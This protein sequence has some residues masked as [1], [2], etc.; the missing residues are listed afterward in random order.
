MNRRFCDGPFLSHQQERPL[1][2]GVRSL[3][4]RPAGFG[5]IG[6]VGV[7]CSNDTS[8]QF[9]Q[10]SLFVNRLLCTWLRWFHSFQKKSY[11]VTLQIESKIEPNETNSFQQAEKA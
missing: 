9:E 3:R 4:Q 5:I 1:V 6:N 7:N 2:G 11:R 10:N 8:S